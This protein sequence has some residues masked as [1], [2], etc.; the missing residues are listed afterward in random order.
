MMLSIHFSYLVNIIEFDAREKNQYVYFEWGMLLE[1][2]VLF[3][4]QNIALWKFESSI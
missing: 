1:V 3:M 2:N 4:M